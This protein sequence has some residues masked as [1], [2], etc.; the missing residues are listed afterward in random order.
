MQIVPPRLAVALTVGLAATA[1]LAA[2]TARTPAAPPS[3][4]G[5]GSAA[6]ISGNEVYVGRPGEFGLF[7]MPPSDAGGIHVFRRGADGAWTEANALAASSPAI[8]DG[9]GE[10]LAISGN[11]LLVGAAKRDSLRGTVFVFERSG[12]NAAWRQ[13][14][15]LKAG[16]AAPGDSLGFAM[17]LGDGVA[18]IGAPGAGTAGAVYVFRHAASG[19]WTQT[20]KLTG[21]DVPEG[22][23]F[24]AA[25]TFVGDR[26]VVGAP[27]RHASPSLFGPGGAFLD[28][29]AYVFAPGADGWTQEAT[30]TGAPDTTRAFGFAFSADPTGVF[31]TAPATG[32]SRGAVYR[33]ERSGSTWRRTAKLMAAKPT[34]GSFL[35]FS[36]ARTGDDLLVGAPVAEHGKGA[37][38]VFRRGADGWTEA[39]SLTVTPRGLLPFTGA[40]VSA[41]GDLAVVGAPGAEFFEGI[42]YVF[43]RD[44]MGKWQEHGSIAERQPD[45]GAV[46]GKKVDCQDGDAGVFPCEQVD[47]QAF[48]PKEALGAGRGIMV[49]DLW[50]WTDPDTKRE[51]AIVGRFD[52][53]SFVDV[54]D[55]TSPRYLGWLPLPDSAHANLWRDIKVYKNYAFI[56]ADAAGPHGV[57]IFDLAQLRSVATPP[58]TFHETA[59]YDGIA[60]AHNIVINEATGFAYVVGAN[61]GGETCGGGLHMVDIRTPTAP[62]FAGCFADPTTGNANTGY[63][64]DA[65]CVVYHGPDTAHDGREICFGANET[66]LSIADVTDKEHPVALSKASYPNVGYAHQGWISEDHQYFYLDDELDELAGTVPRTRTLVWDIQDLDDPVLLTEFLGTTAASDHNLYV[67]DHF[68][69]Q[70]DYVAGLRVI[71][72]ADPANPKEVGYFDTVPHGENA[73]GFAGS[74]SNYPFF[75]SGNIIVSSMREGLFILKK[76]DTQLVP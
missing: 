76:R 26:L 47:L 46:S 20:A 27:G 3:L 29:G 40:A 57:Q 16:D 37:V 56:V 1:P 5:F 68:M 22:G 72:I 44:Q 62:K 33:F 53:T 2:Q 13:T 43:Q 18:A 39:Q 11:R 60:S 67:R 55:P 23:R 49:S 14:A 7:P 54:T 61:S 34:P 12:P 4:I 51:Y 42:G 41:S 70:S 30:L 21:S 73:P 50:G 9:F 58:A 17:V 8:G 19:T 15:E 32:A 71:D 75:A 38:V 45:L 69:Y 28:G 74:W 59:H 63:S 10:A 31:V 25:V 35:G 36:V 64:H 24:G 48:M 52:G 6:V 66:A 65:M